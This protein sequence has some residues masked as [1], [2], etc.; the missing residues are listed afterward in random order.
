MSYAPITPEGHLLATQDAL[1]AA[2]EG[3]AE[4]VRARDD[5]IRYARSEGIPADRIAGILDVD[6]QIVYR[7]LKRTN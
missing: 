4:A 2:Q 5:A 7:A 1:D 6:R 3:Q